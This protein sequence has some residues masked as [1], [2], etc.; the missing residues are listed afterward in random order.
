MTNES[1][2][3]Q[4]TY[5]TQDLSTT[6]AIPCDI[7]QYAK[8]KMRTYRYENGSY[9]YSQQAV[10]MEGT[11]QD[12]VL[13]FGINSYAT[14]TLKKNSNYP[15]SASIVDGELV[16]EL[17]DSFHTTFEVDEDNNLYRVIER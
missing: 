7:E 14:L 1:E 11:L 17:N 6:Q 8:I 3:I 13:E 12:I 2:T 10:V 5:T 15:I 9:V 4:Y 16:V